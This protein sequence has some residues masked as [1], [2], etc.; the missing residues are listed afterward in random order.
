MGYSFT[1]ALMQPFGLTQS[2]AR[3]GAAP[4]LR[5]VARWGGD[6][7]RFESSL[8]WIGE[9]SDFMRLRNKTFNRELHEISSRVLGKSKAA[10]VY[11]ASLFYLTTKMQAIADVPTWIGRYEQALT[12][13]FDE[14]AAVAQADEAVLGSQGGGQVKDLAEVQRKHPLLTQFYSYFATTLNLTI[15]KTATTDFKDPRAVAGWLADMALLVVIPAIVPA[16]LT[17]LLRGEDDER[18]MAKKLAQWQAS[19]LLGMAVG[20]RE[21]SGPVS[22]YSYTGP[23][24]GRIVGDVGKAGQ[25]VAQ[26]EIDEPAVLAAIRLMGSA[27]GIPTVQAVRSYKGWQAWSEGR[28]PATAVLFGPPA[29]D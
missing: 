3:I 20:A 14:A 21:L 25:Q 5:G 9:K 27:F 12:H 26:G 4:V 15:E 23:P 22:G 17:D 18:K 13:G 7:L 28:A 16:L 8:N 24:A 11:D 1:T 10:Q 29:K 6:A 2:I 19:Y